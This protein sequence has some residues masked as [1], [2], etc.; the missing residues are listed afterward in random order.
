MLEGINAVL[1][2][3]GLRVCKVYFIFP[4]LWKDQ[5]KLPA[6]RL[7]LSC[8]HVAVVWRYFRGVSGIHGIC[9]I[10]YY[11]RAVMICDSNYALKYAGYYS[12][13]LIFECLA[14]SSVLNNSPSLAEDKPLDQHAGDLDYES[15]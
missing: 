2:L 1:L 6:L 12:W 4:R 14:V 11:A 7:D 9:D 13:N 15:T 8:I 3:V 10:S 5:I